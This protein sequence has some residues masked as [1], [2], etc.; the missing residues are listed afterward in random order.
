[1]TASDHRNSCCQM[2][3][4][5]HLQPTTMPQGNLETEDRKVTQALEWLYSAQKVGIKL[6]LENTHKLLNALGL[7]MPDFQVIHIAGTNGKGSVAA[8]CASICEAAGYPTGL[9]TSPHLV[10][11]GERI[12]VNGKLIPPSEIC[13]GLA[14]LKKL[15]A[16]WETTPTFFELVLALAVDFFTR[17]HVRIVVLETGMGGR[18]DATN[19]V[20]SNVAVITPIGMDHRQ[21]LGETLGEIA[22]EK[23]GIFK[24]GVPVIL[25]PQETVA[26]EVLLREAALRG[27]PVRKVTEPWR[28]SGIPLRGS[29]QKWNAAVAVAACRQL[30]PKL[31]GKAVLRGIAQ[32]KWPG[33]FQ[34]LGQRVVLDGAH[35]PA[36]AAALVQ[37][38]KDE[39]PGEKATVIFGALDDKDQAAILAV[40]DPIADSFFFVPVRSERTFD[41]AQF[42]V[43][44]K[45]WNVCRNLQE[46]MDQSLHQP[47]Q[48]LITGS[49]FLVGEALAL[50][51]GHSPPLPSKQ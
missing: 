35:N 14:K 42:R 21:W 34:I 48:R 30:L 2:R 40:L 32:T 37:T 18:L 13:V 19:A 5:M 12:Q 11:F 31:N 1:M 15:V 23:A 20:P 7:A 50:L 3:D 44:G 43:P 22:K 27:S 29:H 4:K 45:K 24:Q 10:E 41:P 17:S 49:L 39:F 47:G 25:A 16:N 9:F 33:R 46:A 8:F 36:A 51:D 28:D 26:E 6:G 38:W